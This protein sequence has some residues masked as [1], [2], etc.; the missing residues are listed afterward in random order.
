MAKKES[1]KLKCGIYK[2]TTV[3]SVLTTL[4]KAGSAAGIAHIIMNGL[5][6]ISANAPEKIGAL[7]ALVEAIHM[8]D[9]LPWCVSAIAIRV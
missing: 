6:S 2:M 4:I 9:W 7:A 5:V 1:D 8:N 3:A